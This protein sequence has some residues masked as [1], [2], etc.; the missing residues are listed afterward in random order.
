[1]TTCPSD[2]LPEAVELKTTGTGLNIVA[3]VAYK[4]VFIDKAQ[5]IGDNKSARTQKITPFS[6][7][8]LSRDT[9][10]AISNTAS[11]LSRS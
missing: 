1:M 7:Y 6:N 11:M 3:I 5:L 2:S 9:F 4:Y 10:A 8:F